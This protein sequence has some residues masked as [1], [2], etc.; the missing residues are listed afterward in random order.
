MPDFASTGWWHKLTSQSHCIL[1]TS[2]KIQF[3]PRVAARNNSIGSTLVAIGQKGVQALW[4]AERNGLGLCFTRGPAGL[5]KIGNAGEDPEINSSV[6]S[7]VAR[8]EM[9]I[10]RCGKPTAD[11]L[12][13]AHSCGNAEKL[14][15][16]NQVRYWREQAEMWRK[17][18]LEVEAA[19]NPASRIFDVR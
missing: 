19:K 2:R 5:A 12:V 1:F 17:R 9:T 7:T 6:A 8:P 10:M 11:V 3:L 18:C 15:E 16:C 4:N 13:S 14:Q